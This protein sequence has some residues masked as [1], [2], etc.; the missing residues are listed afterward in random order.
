MARQNDSLDSV[1]GALADPTRR[2]ILA[3]LIEGHASV[4]ELSEPFDISR[5]AI[6]RHL[7]VLESAGLLSRET[8][9]RMHY[10]RLTAGPMLAGL[11]WISDLL[12][13]E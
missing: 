7:R 5:P 9:G 13:G 4:S 12:V 2:E 10:C 11:E 3:R 6:S 1:F 8:D